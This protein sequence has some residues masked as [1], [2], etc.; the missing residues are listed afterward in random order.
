MQHLG[1]WGDNM[2]FTFSS[3]WDS[4][5][6]HKS[7]IAGLGTSGEIQAAVSS[8]C[9][10][11]SSADN[12]VKALLTYCGAASDKVTVLKGIHQAENPSWVGAIYHVTVSI[13]W[14]R[15]S[16]TF[17]VYFTLTVIQ[18]AK[19]KT[20]SKKVWKSMPSIEKAYQTFTLS[21]VSY[22]W[23]GVRQAPAIT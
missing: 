10:G 19:P 15:G 23:N 17:H 2:P 5:E 11:K 12:A 3:D 1:T 4:S 21:E 13:P 22:I 7:G 18:K 6:N 9:A 14:G 20:I 8:A 16:I